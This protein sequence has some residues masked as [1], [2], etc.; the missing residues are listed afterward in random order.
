[1]AAQ[2]LLP[3]LTSVDC[4]SHVAVRTL[5][6]FP[7]AATAK[8][9]A[10]APSWNQNHSLFTLLGKCRQTL[11]QGATHQSLMPIRQF[12]AHVDHIHRR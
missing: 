9:R 5:N 8:E 2:P 1:M 12:M 10:V 11:H 7:T 6:D 3:P 4:E